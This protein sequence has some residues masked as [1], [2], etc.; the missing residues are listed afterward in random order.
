[1]PNTYSTYI[2]KKKII[3]RKYR[4][5]LNCFGMILKYGILSN[6]IVSYYVNE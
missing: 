4:V 2:K 5:Y 1:M 6:K 3:H